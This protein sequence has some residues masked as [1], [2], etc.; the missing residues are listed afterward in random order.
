[1][2]V[3]GLGLPVPAA[4]GNGGNGIRLPV[5]EIG[6]PVPVADAILEPLLVHAGFLR[7]VECLSEER[8]AWPI[9]K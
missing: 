9:G 6:Q 7:H 2:G 1:M 4:T 8:R 3:I 5:E